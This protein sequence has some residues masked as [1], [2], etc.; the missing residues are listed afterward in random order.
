MKQFKLALF[1]LILPLCVNAQETSINIFEIP[2]FSIDKRFEVNLD[3]GNK[4]VIELSSM[5]MILKI[6]NLDSIIS[7]FTKTLQALRDSIADTNDHYKIDYLMLNADDAAVRLTRYPSAS[8]QFLFK[9]GNVN[10]L[11]TNQDT[12]YILGKIEKE[13]NKTWQTVK[14]YE[15]YRVTFLLNHIADIE[16]LENLNEQVKNVSSSEN[17]K[18]N[19]AAKNKF[20]SK[21]FDNIYANGNAGAVDNGKFIYSDFSI[22]L[23]N[24]GE[25]LLGSAR[26]STGVIIR[27]KEIEHKIG[28]YAELPLVFSKS[29]GNSATSD[30][31]F[32]NG[33]IGV[34][35]YFKNA[36][37]GFPFGRSKNLVFPYLTLG[38]LVR[39]DG[40]YFE[41]NTF[42]VGISKFFF[43]DNTL[44]VE[45]MFFI[46]KKYVAP[47]IKLTVPLF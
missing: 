11:K 27:R 32:K 16:A 6:E 5:S 7:E 10:L 2:P 22:G 13:N 46:N 31:S 3:K 47:S 24:Y 9:N 38:Y 26:L 39:R 40:N 14:K 18:W 37:S 1:C 35:Y 17:G 23:Q 34:E 30:R 33:F 19:F 41:K 15:Y 28:F 20:V 8:D 42:Q 44:S 4:M 36:L 29:Y 25:R 45:P 21:I 43:L 12:I